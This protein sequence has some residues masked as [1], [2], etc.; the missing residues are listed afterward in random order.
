VLHLSGPVTVRSCWNIP[1]D[2]YDAGARDVAR[3]LHSFT[4]DYVGFGDSTRPADGAS[5]TPMTQVEPLREVLAHLQRLRDVT[6]GIDLV[7]ES[8][9]GGIATQLATD[10]ALVRSVV[11]STILYTEMSEAA[12]AILLSDEYRAHLDSF[13]DGYLVTDGDYYAQFTGVSPAEVGEWFASTQP[14]RYPT[15]F[16]LFLYEGLP[17]FDPSV[18]R[19]PGLVLPGPG[20]FVPAA[21]A[22]EALARDYGKD[23]AELTFVEDGAHT[24]RFEGS[25]VAE[26]Y[27]QHV[28]DFIDA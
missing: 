8:I 27:W 13:A 26:R 17:Y 10:D 9:G 19:A 12:A 23:G 16:F 28:Y 11:L 24:P 14:G 6:V 2:G 5:V 15:G 7:V 22:A 1:V 4:V 21:G 18:A 3:Q 25:A 20:D